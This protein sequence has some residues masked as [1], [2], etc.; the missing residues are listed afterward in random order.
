MPDD[1]EAIGDTVSLAAAAEHMLVLAEA[2]TLQHG[3]ETVRAAL[4]VAFAVFAERTIGRAG[5]LEAGL[6]ED[7][8]KALYV[9]E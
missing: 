5:L 1:D 3:P 4:L 6:T 9:A 8:L 7:D 2:L